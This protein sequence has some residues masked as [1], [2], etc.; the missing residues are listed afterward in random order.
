MG[1]TQS[2]GAIDYG[3]DGRRTNYRWQVRA[4][5][6]FATTVNYMDR[7]VLGLLA[8]QLQRALHWN[9]AQYS[10]I[11]IAFTAAYA[12]G[13]FLNGR[14]LDAVGTKVGYAIPVAVWSLAS[15]SHVR[16]RSWVGCAVSRVFLGLG[17]SGNFPAA[18]KTTAEWFPKRDRAL[19]AGVFNSGSNLGV[20]VAA[21]VVPFVAA[22]PR[23][24]WRYAFCVTR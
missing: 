21:L 3:T 10:Y 23:L 6:L 13:L 18:V 8:P 9:E 14:L 20:I 12:V 22:A 15:L 4:L 1:G 19:A 24:G 7:Q 16:A 11:S 5:L 17:E 2:A